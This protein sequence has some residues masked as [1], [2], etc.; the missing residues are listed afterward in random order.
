MDITCY[1]SHG[2]IERLNEL[3]DEVLDIGDHDLFDFVYNIKSSIELES[4][5]IDKHRHIGRYYSKLIRIIE[6]SVA[7]NTPGEYSRL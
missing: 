2:L 3:L 5:K 1:E 7:D 6:I 4:D